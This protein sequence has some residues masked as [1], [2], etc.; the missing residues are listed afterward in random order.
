MLLTVWGIGRVPH[1]SALSPIAP[2]NFF[3]VGFSLIPAPILSFQSTLIRPTRHNYAKCIQANHKDCLSTFLSVFA[4]RCFC[5]CTGQDQF[6]LNSCGRHRGDSNV[7]KY[8]QI[9][10]AL[11]P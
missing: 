9:A 1:R 3:Q 4:T 8:Y 10:E 11:G 7:Y 5:R 2:V 6:E